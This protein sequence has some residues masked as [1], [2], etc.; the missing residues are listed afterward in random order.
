MRQ[1]HIINVLFS[2][3]AVAMVGCGSPTPSVD[4]SAQTVD[5]GQSSQFEPYKNERFKSALDGIFARGSDSN[6][7]WSVAVRAFGPQGQKLALYSQS[8]AT[9]VKPA[10]TMKIL[11]SWTAFQKFSSASQIGSERYSYIREMMKYSDN[12]MADQVLASCGGVSASYSMLSAFGIQKSPSLAIVDGSGLSYDNKLGASDLVQL[13]TLIR[14]SDKIKAFRSLLPVGGVDGTLSNRLGHIPGKIAAKTG[15]LTTDPTTAL[16]GF[17]DSQTGWQ[18]VFAMLGDSVPSVDNGRST[19][20]SAVE[21]II[22]TLN[23]FPSKSASQAA[24]Q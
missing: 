3:L 4:S 10:S 11:T 24:A 17:G 6:T 14:S 21:E 19:I 16:A 18:I 20:D 12:Y 13:L 9:V 5:V 2:L 23:Y 22:R 1:S 7:R 15:T 8:A